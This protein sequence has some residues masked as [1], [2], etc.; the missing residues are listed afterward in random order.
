MYLATFPQESNVELPVALCVYG[1]Y[2]SLSEARTAVT[3]LLENEPSVDTLII[4]QTLR[5]IPVMKPLT[6][7]ADEEEEVAAS[8]NEDE[9]HGRIMRR[10]H[11]FC[12]SPPRLRDLF[13]KF[14]RRI[15]HPSMPVKVPPH[16][17]WPQKHLER[18]KM[19]KKHPRC[20]NTT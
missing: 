9:T 6:G 3:D 5:W 19:R 20:T 1:V 11:I 17:S 13:V 14:G 8:K 12:V 10:I 2:A 18:D 16:L 7:T 4:D 15:A